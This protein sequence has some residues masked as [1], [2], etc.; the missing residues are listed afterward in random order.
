M[1]NDLR[2]ACDGVCLSFVY[3]EDGVQLCKMQQ[4]RDLPTGIGQLE[5]A[6]RFPAGAVALMALL[7]LTLIVFEKCRSARGTDG[8][9]DSAER[10]NQFPKAAAI[11]VRNFLEVDKD[12]VVSLCYFVANPIPELRQRVPRGDAA[13]ERHDGHSRIAMRHLNFHLG[14]LFLPFRRVFEDR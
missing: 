6:P 10:K 14:H 9:R 12:L 8:L 7:P 2:E 3:V 11:H 4:I 13:C 1:R 5:L